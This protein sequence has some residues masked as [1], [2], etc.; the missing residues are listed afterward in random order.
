MPPPE[1]R[2]KKRVRKTKRDEKDKCEFYSASE[3]K[4]WN[5]IEPGYIPS[6]YGCLIVRRRRISG[7]VYF[8]ALSGDRALPCTA[9]PH[10]ESIGS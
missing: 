8:L 6:T 4:R 9:F 5:I 10:V 1:Q 3:H 2:K 7:A